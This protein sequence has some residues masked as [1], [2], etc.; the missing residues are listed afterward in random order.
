MGTKVQRPFEILSA[1]QV[2]KIDRAAMM[3]LMKL[4]VRMQHDRVLRMLDDAGAQVDYGQNVAKLPEPLVREALRK[5]PRSYVAYGRDPEKACFIGEDYVHMR[6][7]GTHHMIVDPIGK[8]IRPATLKD[9]E[10]G[11][12]L[13]DGLEHVHLTGNPGTGHWTVPQD[14]PVQIRDLYE[15]KALWEYS[16]KPGAGH[17]YTKKNA[18]YIIKMAETIAGDAEELRSK[19]MI[20]YECE[21]TSPLVYSTSSLEIMEEYASRGLQISFNP[22]PLTGATSPVTFAGT[23]ALHV[24]EILSGIVVAQ[25]IN[26]GTPVAYGCFACP[27]DMRTCIQSFGSANAG[28]LRAAEAQLARHYKLPSFSMALTTDSKICDAQAGYEM[29][30]TMLLCAL[31]GC[32]SN[33]PGGEIGADQGTCYEMLVIADEIA[34]SVYRIIDGLDVSE[35]TLAIELIQKV[36]VGG[37]YLAQAHTRENYPKEHFISSLFDNYDWGT[38]EKHGAT[39]LVTRA[40]EKAQKIIKTHQPEPLDSDIKTE[41]DSVLKDAEREVL[42]QPI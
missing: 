33:G 14:V 9:L 12:R 7:G 20:S 28:L 23:L 15:W 31:S 18:G 36:G 22:M 5:A 21:G 34:G 2:D 37:Q 3:V 17:T 16:G 8:T 39:D 35:D 41:L 29:G 10:D 26:P 38:W 11:T 24:A 32:N 13:L 42:R 4:G 1:E 19:P 25:L 6:G 40:R 27:F 30:M